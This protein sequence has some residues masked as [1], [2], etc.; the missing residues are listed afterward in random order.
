MSAGITPMFEFRINEEKIKADCEDIIRLFFPAYPDGQENII[1]NLLI[2]KNIDNIF[3]CDAQI[4]RDEKIIS[5]YSNFL[6][7]DTNSKLIFLKHLKRLAKDTLYE[8]LIGFTG[9]VLPWGSLTG[10]RPTRLVYELIEQGFSSQEALEMFKEK[11]KVSPQKAELTGKIIKSQEGIYTRDD[12]FI[13]LY[14]NIPVCTT[15]C[16]YCSFISST[17]NKCRHLLDD[18][19]H[20]LKTEIETAIDITKQKG[21]KLRSVYVGGGT[22][23]ALSASQLKDILSVIP[24]DIVEFTVEAG[25]PDTITE[26]KLS[27]LSEEKV[28]RISIN[29]QSFS[30]EV[31]NNIGR[32]HT[33]QEI[34]DAYAMA[35]KYDFVI[36]MDLIAGLSGESY[37]SFCNSIEKAL[38]LKPDNITV[39]TLSIKGGS[40]LKQSGIYNNHSQYNQ[41]VCDM[42]EYAYNRLTNNGY[43]PYYMYRQKY[44]LGNLENVGYSLPNK[45]CINNI[46]TM[47]D[48]ISVI[49]CGAGAISKRLFGEGRIERVANVK[50]IDEYIARFEEMLNRKRK[51]FLDM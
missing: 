31:L 38:E 41:A 7:I 34:F 1:I 11:Y 18:Y 45:Y 20:L 42:V 46:D 9:R 27:V 3:N 50:N 32:G 29:P 35:R 51:L 33:V 14:V 48:S 25:R 28:S 47:E 2:T 10:I 40:Q 21:Y 5:K 26:E 16:N 4:I 37:D 8:A 23:T 12:N 17:L 43:E 30:Q 13:N 49:A 19:C 36:N 24:K 22:P 44:M 6:A 39:H 15:R